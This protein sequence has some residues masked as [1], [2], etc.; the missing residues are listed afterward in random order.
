MGTVLQM[1]GQ[2][3]RIQPLPVSFVDTYRRPDQTIGKYCM[4]MEIT[5]QCPVSFRI[6]YTNFIS[7]LSFTPK[8]K[9]E[10]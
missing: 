2:G 10:N 9:T 8:S 7:D 3:D 5:F 1:F 6:G 4:Y